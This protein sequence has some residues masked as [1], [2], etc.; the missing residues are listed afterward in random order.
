MSQKVT[1]FITDRDPGAFVPQG[2]LAPGAA[3]GGGLVATQVTDGV[4]TVLPTSELSFTSGVTV[5]DLGAGVAGIAVSGGSPTGSAGGDLSGTY[6]NPAVAKINGSPLGTVSGASTNDVLTWNG[7]AWV[8]KAPSGSSP[9]TTK[10]DLFGHSTVDARIPIG[11]DTYV[12]T[13]D[14]AQ[15]LGLKW[16]AP[17]GGGGVSGKLPIQS[18]SYGSGG[19]NTNSL[20]VT[21][22]STPTNGNLLFACIGRD[23]TGAISSIT[24]TGVTWTQF[25][26]S[27]NST[28]PVVEIWKGV[29]GAGAGTTLTIACATTTYTNAVISEWNGYTGTLDQSASNSGI[30]VAVGNRAYTPTILPTSANALVI[31]ACTTTSNPAYG[32]MVGVIPFPAMLT[33]GSTVAAGY[34]FPGTTPVMGLNL[35]GGS[36]GTGSGV[37]VS[38]T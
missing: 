13:A 5:T 38:L 6:P 35:T 17:G 27:G 32:P 34:A 26:T 7:S 8:H 14:S 15:T 33:T 20:A 29:I 37:I 31:A 2:A 12:L 36:T 30:T 1:R 9:L 21:L 22:G 4:H 16:A 3:F 28:A 10:G 23:A 18:K 24:Q 11:T 25:A 19:S